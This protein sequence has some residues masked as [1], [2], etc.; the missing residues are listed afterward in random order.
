VREVERSALIRLRR[1]R[2]AERL[3]AYLD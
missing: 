1:G 2:L 3:R